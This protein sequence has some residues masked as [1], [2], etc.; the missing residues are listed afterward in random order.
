ML[1]LILN[2][3]QSHEVSSLLRLPFL[4]QLMLALATLFL[5]SYCVL[6]LLAHTCGL[7]VTLPCDLVIVWT[8]RRDNRY[9]FHF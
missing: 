3:D 1:H 5:G 2:F 9:T 4:V 8:Y 7:V 6:A